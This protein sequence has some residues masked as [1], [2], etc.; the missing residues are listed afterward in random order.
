MEFNLVEHFGD[1][2]S[3]VDKAQDK[4]FPTLNNWLNNREA[5][6]KVVYLNANGVKYIGY[7]YAKQTFRKVIS[8]LLSNGYRFQHIC[9]KYDKEDYKKVFDG[10]IY[11]L[12]QKQY[13]MF[14][15]GSIFDKPQ[16]IGYLST[17]D[18]FESKKV[19]RKKKKQKTVLEYI[20]NKKEVFTNDIA[21]AVDLKLPYTNRILK[22]LEEKKLIQRDKEVSPSGGFIYLNKSIF[23]P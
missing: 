21:D 1:Q 22:E 17:S 14:L 23:K 12:N 3:D 4:D 16:I 15:T 5:T 8:K 18:S 6:N 19:S 7:S 2:L 10:L 13:S 11:A 9:F 20:I